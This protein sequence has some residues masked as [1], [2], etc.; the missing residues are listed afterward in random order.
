MIIVIAFY[1]NEINQDF[2]P[3]NNENWGDF[4]YEKSLNWLKLS[5]KK[6]FQTLLLL[7]I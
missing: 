3:K 6:I 4:T 2:N 1:R 5:L 7:S